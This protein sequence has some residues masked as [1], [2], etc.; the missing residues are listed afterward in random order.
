MRKDGAKLRLTGQPFQVLTILLEQPGEVVTREELQKRLWPDTFVDVDHNLNTAINKIREALG[1]S[2][3]SPCFVETLPRRGYRF[4]AQ[5][6]GTRTAEPPGASGVRQQPRVRWVRLT[7]I[8]FVVL[9]LLAAAGF[10]IYRRLQS[11]ASLAQR[12]LTRL[13]LDDGLQI[14]ATWSPDGRFIA[15]SSNRGGK[16]DIWVQQ[17]SGGDPVEITKG[18]GHNWQPDWSPDGNFI[19]YRSENGEGGLFVV[20]ALG[21]EGL[22][23]RIA[24]F[25]YYPRWSPDSSQILFQ[26]TPLAVTN[27]FYISSLNGSPPQEVLRDLFPDAFASVSAAW[28]P[29]GK[30]ITAWVWDS[31]SAPMPTF[32]TEP[33]VGGMAIRTKIPAELMRQVA[34]VGSRRMWW[35]TDFKFSWAPSG[36]AIY[37][38]RTS[39]AARNI[40][41]M[42][43]DPQTL[44]AEAIERLTTGPGLDTELSLSA[45]GKKLAFTGESRRIRAWLFPFDATRGRVLGSG[46]AVTSPGT[47][48]WQPSLSRDGR[49]LAFSGDRGGNLELR[50]KSLSDGREVPIVADDFYSRYYPQWSPDGAYLAYTRE[51]PSGEGRLM[52]WSSQSRTE[53]PLTTSSRTGRDAH[54]W[55]GD[56]K[57]LLV[58]QGKDVWVLPVASRPN[59]EAAA[60]KIT[61]SPASALY[62]CHFSP[63]GRWI[64]FEAVRNSPVESILYV[65]AATGGP[66]IRITDG[67]HWDDKPRWSPDGKTIYFVSGRG[68]FFNVW[69]IRFDAVKGKP[70]GDPFRVTSFESPSLMVP[71]NVPPVELSLTQEKLVLTIAEVSGSIW[72]LDNVGP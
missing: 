67:K 44:K 46:H 34:E 10:F 57:W 70:V 9:V 16:F 15:Y 45:D 11:P 62:Q 26:T 53:E 14:G 19:A 18:P 59:A 3:E 47:D 12:T 2:A 50:E 48:A 63:D 23:R 37:F 68:G 33:I 43:V 51:E 27:R 7:A 52:M 8:L 55:S 54:D 40:W 22:E 28:H 42:S 61:S 60:Q 24:S 72:I 32:W 64:V 30:R 13:T 71:T 25:G 56:G 5:V 4:V 66:W 21:G 38:E 69:G 29:D 1:D 49:K 41:R 17:V 35:T 36:R 20:P 6:E 58:A 31:A 39:R 65:M